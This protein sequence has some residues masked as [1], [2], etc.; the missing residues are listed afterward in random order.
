M[1]RLVRINN[2]LESLPY[3]VSNDK[4]LKI[5]NDLYNLINETLR[6]MKHIN[7]KIEES[8]HTFGR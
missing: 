2:N 6:K 5:L 7:E 4:E 8:L 3:L 1:E